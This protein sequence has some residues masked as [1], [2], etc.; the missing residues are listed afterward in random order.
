MNSAIASCT[1]HIAPASTALATSPA[2]VA[3]I[4]PASVYL[5]FVTFAVI[6]YT[7]MV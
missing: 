3:S 6:K 7:L 4:A 1:P 2:K 5:V